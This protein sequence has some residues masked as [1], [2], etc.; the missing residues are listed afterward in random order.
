[1]QMAGYKIKGVGAGTPLQL[2]VRKGLWD[3]LLSHVVFN[4][5][6]GDGSHFKILKARRVERVWR[7]RNPAISAGKVKWGLALENRQFLRR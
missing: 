5:G 2:I 4:V 3:E 6:R 7:N 1:M